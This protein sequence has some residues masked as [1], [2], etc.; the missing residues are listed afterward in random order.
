MWLLN[1]A[2]KTK[3]F[4]RLSL[5]VKFIIQKNQKL[6]ILFFQVDSS[7]FKPVFSMH[8]FFHLNYYRKECAEMQNKVEIFK[9]GIFIPMQ[10]INQANI[11]L[12]PF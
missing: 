4:R 1:T 7:Q 11:K 6:N 3:Y 12:H 2:I 5:K 8:F 10:R 9:T